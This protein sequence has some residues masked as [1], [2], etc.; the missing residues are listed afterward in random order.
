M[1]PP[2]FVFSLWGFLLNWLF[3]RFNGRTA[4]LWIANV[5]AALA[6]G[7][8]HLGNAS[9]TGV[10]SIAELGPVLLSEIFPAQWFCCACRRRT[11]MKD[12]LI[13]AAGVHFWTDIVF[14]VM[15]GLV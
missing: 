7:A 11:L 14:H 10:S 12:G 3:K 5:I 13:A 1:F 15:W 2:V 8:S 4:A 6:F 9:S